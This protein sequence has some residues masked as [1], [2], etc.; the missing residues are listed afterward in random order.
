LVEGPE[1]KNTSMSMD[2]RSCL[3]M[4]IF[5][6][7]DRIRF[8]LARRGGDFLVVFPLGLWSQREGEGGGRGEGGG[9][10]FKDLA[11]ETGGEINKIYSG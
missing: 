11:P 3:I 10:I 2:Q 7:L 1:V 8:G 9:G 4:K 5:L 6:F